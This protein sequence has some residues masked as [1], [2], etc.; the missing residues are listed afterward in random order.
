MK[1]IVDGGLGSRQIP[2]SQHGK[3]MC[4]GLSL[5]RQLTY[6]SFMSYYHFMA[7]LRSRPVNVTYDKY[8]TTRIND[9][10][11]IVIPASIRK[12]M[13]LKPGNVVTMSVEDGVLRVEAHQ[14][15]IRRIQAEFKKFA[16][17]GVRASEE[18]IS[19]RR[20]EAQQEL[21]E[22]LG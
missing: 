12:A 9:N 14:A 15:R 6:S 4:A 7:N 5:L 16:T 2:A 3:A 8:V 18:L 13:G 20:E 22:W 19:R 17:P 11:R 1:P 21:E 10:G